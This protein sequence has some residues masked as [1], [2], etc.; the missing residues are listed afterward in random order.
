M[1]E[2]ALEGA[3]KTVW[4][5]EIGT[6]AHPKTDPE[7]SFHEFDPPPRDASLQA[8]EE[9]GIDHARSYGAGTRRIPASIGG[10][11]DGRRKPSGGNVWD[12]VMD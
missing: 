11:R 8:A 6:G 2:T 12:E 10:T 7:P 5:T 3:Q 4:K 1:P 9:A